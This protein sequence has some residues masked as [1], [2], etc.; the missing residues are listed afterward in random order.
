ME[1]TVPLRLGRVKPQSLNCDQPE[2]VVR[3]RAR[4]HDGNWLVTLFLANAQRGEADR[5]EA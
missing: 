1:S 3:G 2:T 5:S 4:K